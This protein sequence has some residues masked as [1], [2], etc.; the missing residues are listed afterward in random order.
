MKLFIVSLSKK[1]QKV[2]FGM[3]MIMPL[4]TFCQRVT[5]SHKFWEKSEN[6]A[7]TGESVGSV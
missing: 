2:F 5:K 7:P 6:P 4:L 3:S 1:N